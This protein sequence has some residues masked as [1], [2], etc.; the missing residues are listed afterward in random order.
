M[1]LALETS[2][3]LCSVAVIANGK[4]KSKIKNNIKNLHAEKLISLIDQTIKNINTNLKSIDAIAISIGPGSFTG[5][6]VGLSVAKGLCYAVEKPLIVVPTLD[7]L[8]LKAIKICKIVEK[9]INN[10]LYICPVLNA[11]QN[12]FYYSLYKFKGGELARSMPYLSGSLEEIVDK[13]REGLILIGDG[14]V[15]LKEK[16]YNQNVIFVDEDEFNQP[17]AFYVGKIAEDKYRS[18]DFADIDSVEPLYV[19]EFT[20]K[21][22]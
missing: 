8:A 11:K 4:T 19:K 20:V 13:V 6:R 7:A 16:L 14:V 10:D 17:D 21:T 1:I 5:L 15:N 3:D 2:T 18:G 22:K 9:Y 12:D